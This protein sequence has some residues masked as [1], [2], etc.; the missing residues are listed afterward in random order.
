[1]N[2]GWY[3]TETWS[4]D[5]MKGKVTGEQVRIPHT[6]KMLDYH[7][8]NEKDYQMVCGYRK[9]LTMPSDLNNRRVFVQLDGAGHIATVFL[10]GKEVGFHQ[11]GYTAFR[12]ELTDHVKAGK[13]HILAVKLDSTE[14]PTVPPFGFV[15]DYLTYGGI[16]RD[17]YLDITDDIYV[18][19]IFVQ[20]PTLD[21]AH[22]KITLSPDKEMAKTVIIEDAAGH[23]V[24]RHE[25]V[26]NTVEFKGL[27]VKPWSTD[28]PNL[29]SC[30]VILAGQKEEKRVTFGFRT[31]AWDNKSFYLNGKKLFF[32]G[33]NRHQSYPYIGYAATASLQYEDARILKEELGCNAV[34]TS[35]YP[36]SQHFIDACDK[37]GLLVFTEIPGWQ[38]I[39]DEK[40]QDVAVEHTREMVMQY[41]N[42]PSIFLWGVR[43]NESQDNEK[44]Y[45]RTNKVA[46]DLDP[47][48]LTSGVRYIE[49]SQL[50]EDVYAYNDFS[51]NG[52]TP[53]AKPKDKVTKEDKPLLI[54]ESN[55][56]MF[57]TKPFDNW[58]RRQ[59][60]ALRHA[61]VLNAAMADGEHAGCYQWCMFDYPTHKDFGSGDRVCY[62]G[63]MDSFRNPKLASYVY[64]S[65]QDDYPV[66]EVSS[67]MDIGDYPAGLIG[68]I[69][70]FSN[71]IHFSEAPSAG[72]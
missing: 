11:G 41:R 64:S 4:E 69:Y 27:D 1:M 17:V 13:K 70:V 66:L 32:R 3:F 23:E 34:R 60:H 7:Y 62:H 24:A 25:G 22:I 38:H 71:G 5:F 21:S 56:H 47:S 2:S 53:G 46:H 58:E 43:I 59:E 48:R 72:R 68:K 67:T 51:H 15:I 16:Y 28:E 33:L 12:V 57:P 10:D 54:S 35:H 9:E 63:V 49:N 44:F 18:E 20:T 65:Q 39:G 14:N 55:G 8:I 31:V 61:R 45:L 40:W 30:K 6:V 19:D 52:I 26:E 29:Y 37:L 50:L 42:H 36:Q